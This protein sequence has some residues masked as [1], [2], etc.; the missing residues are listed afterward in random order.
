[1]FET[2]VVSGNVSFYNETDGKGILP[3][4]TIGMVGLIE[5]T[6]KIVTHG[7]KDEGDIIALLGVTQDD[8]S[9]SEFAASVAGRTTSEMIESGR[10]PKI[11]LDAEKLVQDTCLKLIESGVIKSAHDCS[12]GG[13]AVTIAE[14]CFSSL[15]GDAV[16]ASID[17]ATPGLSSEAILF[18][19]SPSRIVISFAADDLD[20]VKTLVGD[21]PFTVLGAVADDVLR[22]TVDGKEAIGSPVVELEAVWET[23]LEMKLQARIAAA[24]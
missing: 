4:P 20:R 10:V 3:T 1:M 24:K 17:L 22:I 18:A 8:L 21:C 12:E 13:I 14:C 11:D 15:G 6:R 19:E 2:P 7:F 5:D 23:A 16:G 9:V